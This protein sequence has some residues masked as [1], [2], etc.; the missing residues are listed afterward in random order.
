MLK[1]F[2]KQ[3]DTERTQK[4]LSMCSFQ[5]LK[6]SYICSLPSLV[7]WIFS[8]L[9][10]ISSSKIQYETF[11][12]LFTI[13]LEWQNIYLW[14]KSHFIVIKIKSMILKWLDNFLANCI[15]P[16]YVYE[17]IFNTKVGKMWMLMLHKHVVFKKKKRCF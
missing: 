3:K 8:M 12:I 4:H 11:F 9:L 14:N 7:V 5:G 6:D 17:P 2:H 13:S 16:N 15:V 10:T 1:L